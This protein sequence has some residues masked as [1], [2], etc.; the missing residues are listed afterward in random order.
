MMAVVAGLAGIVVL[1]LGAVAGL[2]GIE[3]ADQALSPAAPSAEARAEIP[4]GL[5]EIYQ[6]AA[7]ACEG[8][9]WQVIAAVFWAES[10]HGQGR[11][12]PATGNVWPPI[13]GPALDGR[14][15]FA[16]IADASSPDGWARALVIS[17]WDPLLWHVSR[18]AQ[19]PRAIAV[20]EGCEARR[21]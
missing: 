9:P 18:V 2:A 16:A 12:D 5:V 11:V 13:V 7:A 15:G 8:L 20:S 10:R 17:G 19:R 6:G 3:A 4:P 21:S 14:P 1:S